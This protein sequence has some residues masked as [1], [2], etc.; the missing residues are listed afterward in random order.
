MATCSL[1]SPPKIGRAWKGP[2]FRAGLA[3]AYVTAFAHAAVLAW[4]VGS[5]LGI[6][7]RGA[8]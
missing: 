1:S 7:I 2:L 6:V 8:A 4:L 5:I 3:L